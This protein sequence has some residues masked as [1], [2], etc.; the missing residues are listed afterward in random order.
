MGLA[1]QVAVAWVVRSRKVGSVLDV[2]CR[3]FGKGLRRE[4]ACWLFSGIKNEK[5][6]LPL[7]SCLLSFP[8][9]FHCCS[10]PYSTS[11]QICIPPCSPTGHNLFVAFHCSTTR[12]LVHCF[13]VDGKVSAPQITCFPQTN[14][15]LLSRGKH[16]A[17]RHSAAK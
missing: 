15:D 4:H 2:P 3:D 7:S 8:L 9:F 17:L 14:S 13:W 1:T 10:H 16:G 5:H 12:P 11:S 6:L